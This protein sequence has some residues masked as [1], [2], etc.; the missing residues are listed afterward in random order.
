MRWTAEDEI[1]LH[2]WIEN[3][4]FQIVYL[5]EV[6]EYGYIHKDKPQEINGGFKKFIDLKQHFVDLKGD[7]KNVK[8]VSESEFLQAMEYARKRRKIAKL[9]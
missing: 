6:E 4:G 8:I 1:N 7:K 5:P 9:H 2:Q 3:R